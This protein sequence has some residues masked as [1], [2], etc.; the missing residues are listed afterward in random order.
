LARRRISGFGLEQHS[1]GAQDV[2]DVKVFEVFVQ[3]I[4]QPVAGEI[5]L[6]P[7]GVVLQVAEARLAHDPAAHHAAGDAHPNRLLVEKI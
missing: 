2:A 5:E 7:A 4:R 1:F 6:D 3:P